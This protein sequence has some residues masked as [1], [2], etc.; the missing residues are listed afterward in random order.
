MLLSFF[1]EISSIYTLR[2]GL[3]LLNPTIRFG[4]SD[5]FFCYLSTFIKFFGASQEGVLVLFYFQSKVRSDLQYLRNNIKGACLR[6]RSRVAAIQHKFYTVTVCLSIDSLLSQ[7]GDSFSCELG[8]SEDLTFGEVF[9]LESQ[10]HG[11]DCIH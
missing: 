7:K 2:F 11:Y 9:N 10:H 3:F 5:K 4:L 6:F 1:V 8:K